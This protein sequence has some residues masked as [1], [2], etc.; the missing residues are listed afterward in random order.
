MT[1]VCN[2]S[3][4]RNYQTTHLFTYVCQLISVSHVITSTLFLRYPRV[5]SPWNKRTS[6]F[7]PRHSSFVV[8][9]RTVHWTSL[10]SLAQGPSIRLYRSTDV[11]ATQRTPGSER[12]P[13][14]TVTELQELK[15]YTS[16]RKSETS[17]PGLN[18]SVNTS[19]LG[20]RSLFP[21]TSFSSR[22]LDFHRDQTGEGTR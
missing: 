20:N 12:H 8:S 15:T 5:T 2:Y 1:V 7:L 11:V 21:W 10:S 22:P 18:P 16:G 14:T 13:E 9:V 3:D 6:Q 19:T 17:F 4:I